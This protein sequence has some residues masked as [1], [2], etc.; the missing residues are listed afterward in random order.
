MI[1]AVGPGVPHT[2]TT[3]DGLAWPAFLFLA[4]LA[5]GLLQLR[6]SRREVWGDRFAMLAPLVHHI[7]R[8]LRA[9]PG[10]V[11]QTLRHRRDRIGLWLHQGQIKASLERE[12]QQILGR[13]DGETR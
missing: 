5:Y 12:L 1:L 11:W 2:A 8:D 3:S 6:P 9:I 13:D 4:L 7:G 10:A